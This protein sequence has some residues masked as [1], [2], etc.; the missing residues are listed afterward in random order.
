MGEEGFVKGAAVYKVGVAG[1]TGQITTDENTY[2]VKYLGPETPPGPGIKVTPCLV[3][4]D[5]SENRDFA[6]IEITGGHSSPVEFFNRQEIQITD[7]YIDG[8]GM[9]F[10]EGPNGEI[11]FE[12]FDG[13]PEKRGM[14]VT[15]GFGW[16]QCWIA[17]KGGPGMRILE[18]CVPPWPQ[19]LPYEAVEN[20][21]TD[22][23]LSPSARKIFQ[24]EILPTLQ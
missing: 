3:E 15:Y 9:F 19:E 2:Q 13:S 10:A 16:K 24:E 4:G 20:P 18:S 22:E 7:Y 21:A 8:E 1:E 23:R 14:N 17:R 6:D 11:I 12:I 5:N